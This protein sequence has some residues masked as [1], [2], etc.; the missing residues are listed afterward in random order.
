MKLN[1]YYHLMTVITLND[2]EDSYDG[3][4]EFV[5]IHNI[6]S[7]IINKCF[8]KNYFSNNPMYKND[9]VINRLLSFLSIDAKVKTVFPT[10]SSVRFDVIY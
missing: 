5:Y 7:D 2:L 6:S 9:K 4:T 10:P 8:G 1:L 3:F